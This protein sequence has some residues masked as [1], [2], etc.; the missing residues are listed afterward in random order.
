MFIDFVNLASLGRAGIS[1]NS[2]QASPEATKVLHSFLA[3]SD[4][5]VGANMFRIVSLIHQRKNFIDVARPGIFVDTK[6]WIC[7]FVTTK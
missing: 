1:P 7:R 6:Q 2:M 4:R 3:A 5:A